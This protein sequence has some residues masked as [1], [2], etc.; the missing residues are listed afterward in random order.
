MDIER[1]VKMKGVMARKIGDECM[2]YDP[3]KGAVH[4]INSTAEFVWAMCDGSHNIQDITR[5]MTDKFQIQEGTDIKSE[6]ENILK[7]F[8]KIDVIR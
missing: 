5:R 2:L 8:Q 4:V 3:D 6:I 1:P 7:E